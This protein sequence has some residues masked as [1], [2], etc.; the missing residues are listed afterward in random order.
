[1]RHAYAPGTGDPDDF[2]LDDC[3]T[4]RNLNAAGRRQARAMGDWLRTRGI[5]R[6]RVY[7]SQWCRCLD[8]AALLD[9]GPVTPLPA[10]NS[11]FERPQDRAPTLA[12]LRAFL[13]AAPRQGELLILVTH[14]VTISAIA[15]RFM[16]S[17]HGVLLRP[18]AD[19][20]LQLVGEIDFGH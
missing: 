11:F 19:G 15:G 10:L 16:A 13:D 17:G 14:Q 6:T 2:R 5:A 9:L 4:Q 3:S 12:A 20:R 18:G 7:S 8:T 1:M